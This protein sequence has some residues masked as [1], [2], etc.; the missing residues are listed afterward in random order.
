MQ[1][2]YIQTGRQIE[3]QTEMES[4]IDEDKYRYTQSDIKNHRKCSQICIHISERQVD[5]QICRQ[6]ETQIDRV[7][8]R[9][10]GRH[11]CRQAHMQTDTQTGR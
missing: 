1:T 9:Q 5:R 6:T 3:V 10:R 11:I 8:D 2:D 4:D 7:T